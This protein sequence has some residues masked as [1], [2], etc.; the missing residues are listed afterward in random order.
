MAFIQHPENIGE[1]VCITGYVWITGDV[2]ISG[3]VAIFDNARISGNVRISEDAVISGYAEISGDA[4]ISGTVR[5][6]GNAVI[7][8]NAEITEI[9]DFLTL[10]PAKSSRNFTTAHKDSVIGVR[11]NCGCFSG[12]VE[13]FISAIQKTHA[14]NP[15]Y[16][17]QYMAF[18]HV[19]KIHF[20]LPM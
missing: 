17:A 7:S 12:S 3:S 20:N 5:I 19:I 1:N 16:L 14:N 9:S 2:E 6:S 11:V 10:G 15:E 13:E 4:R 8:G 18:V